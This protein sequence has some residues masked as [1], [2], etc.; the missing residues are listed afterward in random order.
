MSVYFDG[1]S[2]SP[3]DMRIAQARGLCAQALHQAGYSKNQINLLHPFIM[4]GQSADEIMKLFG[5]NATKE[6][7]ENVVKLFA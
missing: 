4:K 2:D 3:E 1:L 7:I 5:I 6:E